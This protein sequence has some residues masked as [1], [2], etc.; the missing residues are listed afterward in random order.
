MKKAVLLLVLSLPAFSLP[1]GA[2]ITPTGHT[3]APGDQTCVRCHRSFDLNP[4][5]GSVRVQAVNYKPGQPQTLRVTVSHPDALRWG[6]QIAARWA[7]DPTQNVGTFRSINTETQ[8]QEGGYATH[9]ISGTLAGGANGTKTFELEWTP[10]AGSD[11]SDVIFYAAGNAANN[12]AGQGGGG[13]QGDRIYTTQ[14]RIQADVA[15]GFT[16]R[17]VITGIADAASFNRGV[18][19]GSLLT[20]TGRNLA[21]ANTR[22]EAAMGYVREDRFPTELGCVGVEIDGKRAPLLYVSSEQINVQVPATSNLGDVPVRVIVNADRP[23]Q[24]MSDVATTRMQAVSPALFTFNGRSVAARVAGSAQIIADPA[25]VPGARP[26]RPG[27]LIELYGTGLGATQT[28]VAPGA[29]T[30]AQAIPTTTKATVRL[31]N[32]QLADADV[33]YSGLAGSSISGLYQINV[34]IPTSASNGDIP[35]QVAVGS[36]SSVAGTTI[37]VRA[38]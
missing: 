5:G 20:I 38:Q 34:R 17:P 26:A 6:F 3:G 27:E 4:P 2:P 13:N 21:T 29:I 31:N 36:E 9:T 28:V 12:N 22:R 7:K 25:V 14:T 32:V 11:D 1:T 37:P 15:C 30:P 10:P 16:E 18:S 24:L 8:V 35:I 19:P 33:L 23:N